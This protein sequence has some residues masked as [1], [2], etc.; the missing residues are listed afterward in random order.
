MNYG[1][2]FLNQWVSYLE[3][4]AMLSGLIGVWLTLKQNVWCFPVGILN[5][6]LYAWI[7]FTPDIRLYADAI[8]QCIYLLLLIFGWYVWT[9]SDSNKKFIKPG[10]S[11]GLH[12]IRTLA[13]TFIVAILSGWFLNKYTNAS[14]PFLD[15]ALSSVSLAAQWLVAKKKIE[16]W[17]LWIIV[18]VVYIPVYLSKDLPLTAFLYF[19]FLLLAIKGW[20]EWH[21]NLKAEIHA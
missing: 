2:D 7:F 8:L 13:I 20:K 4:V 3:L 17:I 21:K 5:V 1:F 14:L 16:N 19:L 15:A 12:L 11:S 18:D 9:H 6:A 10:A